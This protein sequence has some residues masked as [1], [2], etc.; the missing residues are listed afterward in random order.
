MLAHVL[1]PLPV[2]PPLPPRPS[3]AWNMATHLQHLQ[4]LQPL[5]HQFLNLAL[6]CLSF[7]FPEGVSCPSLGVF[8]EVVG[9]ELAGLAEEGAVLHQRVS[10]GNWQDVLGM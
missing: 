2:L 7:V 10:R 6:F 3:D 1:R 8:S 4:L 5:L 9:G